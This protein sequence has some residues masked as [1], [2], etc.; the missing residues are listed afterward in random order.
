MNTIILLTRHG[1]TE[2]TEQDRFNGH[3]DIVLGERGRQQAAQL[4]KA[5][6]D[7]SIDTCHASPLR[8]CQ[9]TAQ[10]ALGQR[11]L[12]VITEPE[13]IEMNYGLWEGLTRTEIGQHYPKEWHQWS[14][15]PAGIAPPSGE[16]GYQIA[17]R[18]IPCVIRLVQKHQGKT[19]FVV[20]HNTV[21]RILLA[22]ALG[23]SIS[24]Y[25]RRIVQS[26]SGLSRIE[27][28]SDYVMRV[29]LMNDT[30]HYAS[31]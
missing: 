19:I 7:I 30:S 1:E 15:D 3:S 14:L 21:N 9:E 10:L 27:V 17:A 26:P 12:P 23:V 24:D 18:V 11:A 6:V 31:D 13:L 22:H 2:W 28:G 16:T 25:R 5:L 29:T 4:S 20:A 8:R